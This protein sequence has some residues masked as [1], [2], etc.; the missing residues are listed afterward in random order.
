MSVLPQVVEEN[1]AIITAEILGK[2]QKDADKTLY[3][4]Q[5]DRL[6]VDLIAYRETL[7]RAAMNDAARQNLVD[8]ARDPMLSYLGAFVSTYRLPAQ[9]ARTTL[10]FT[11]L[12]PDAELSVIPKGFRIKAPNESIFAT[13]YEISVSADNEKQVLAIAEETGSGNNGLLQSSFKDGFDELPTG[14]E[15]TNLTTSDG[16]SERE[17]LERFRKRIKLAMSRSS[18]GSRN[19][20]L[21]TAL[22]ADVRVIDV[23]IQILAPGWVRLAVLTDGDANEVVAAVD[24]AVQA[25]DNKPLTDRVDTVMAQPLPVSIEIVLTPG[26]QA[27]LV[28]LIPAAEST[29]QSLRQKLRTTLGYDAISSQISSALQL[30]P[31][32][33]RV[34]LT[35]ADQPISPEEYAVIDWNIAFAEAETP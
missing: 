32:I 28:E 18:A 14:I 31:G 35:G 21:Y 20:Y 16:G 22:S 25:D 26:T 30:I 10:E 15:V 27:T 13:Q 33:K 4:A 12:Q 19:A 29:M 34:L 23:S 2:Y 17:E 6:L 5:S 11:Q 3:D 1:P 7:A 24:K 9:P 8:F